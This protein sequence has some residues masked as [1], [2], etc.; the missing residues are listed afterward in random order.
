MPHSILRLMPTINAGDVVEVGEEPV[1]LH[2]T[3]ASGGR[4][5][6]APQLAAGQAVSAR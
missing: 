1:L 4:A 3:G 5:K 2:I 6:K